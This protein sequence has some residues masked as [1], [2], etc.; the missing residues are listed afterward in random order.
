MINLKRLIQ[1]L[2]DIQIADDKGEV[3]K[4]DFENLNDEL[5]KVLRIEVADIE[6]NVF[7]MNPGPKD[8]PWEAIAEA[9]ATGN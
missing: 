8:N 4:V 6:R 1:L 7:N 3:G 2:Q 5:R 9:E